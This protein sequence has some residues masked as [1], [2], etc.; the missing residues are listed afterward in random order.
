MRTVQALDVTR[1]LFSCPERQ[2]TVWH[3]ICSVYGNKVLRYA[4]GRGAAATLSYLPLRGVCLGKGAGMSERESA[5]TWH[6]SSFSQSGDCV[7]WICS[8]TLVYMRNSN[9]PS[10]RVLEFTHPEWRAFIDG[11]KAG[12]ADLSTKDD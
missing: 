6:R 2:A 3:R 7:E 1:Q 11:V 9:D 5:T 10:K 8:G 4:L 12:E